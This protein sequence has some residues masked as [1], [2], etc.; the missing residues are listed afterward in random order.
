MFYRTINAISTSQ[1]RNFRTNFLLLKPDGTQTRFMNFHAEFHVIKFPS[2]SRTNNSYQLYCKIRRTQNPTYFEILVLINNDTQRVPPTQ[3]HIIV[4]DNQL[5][6]ARNRTTM[7]DIG[8][9]N[10]NKKHPCKIFEIR[11]KTKTRT[12]RKQQYCEEKEGWLWFQNE[13]EKNETARKPPD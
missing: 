6:A 4:Y 7:R 10:L 5:S 2:V 9:R 11:N 13:L 8:T 3:Q 1:T 12:R